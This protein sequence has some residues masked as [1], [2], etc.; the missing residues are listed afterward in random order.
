LFA[1]WG[2]AA[3]LIGFGLFVRRKRRPVPVI[4]NPRAAVAPAA[5]EDVED[6]AT[7]P[8]NAP[9]I[10]IGRNS[11]NDIVLQAPTVGRF[12]AIV[13]QTGDRAYSITDQSSANGTL[14]N[15]KKIDTAPLS[16]GDV[17][18]LGGKKLRFNA[19]AVPQ[20]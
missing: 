1:A 8:L 13:Q 7:Y 18:M 3:V 6:G 10:R 2:T 17:I 12:H 11:D 4:A 16:D 9:L 5:L 20:R 15:N 19:G 14:V